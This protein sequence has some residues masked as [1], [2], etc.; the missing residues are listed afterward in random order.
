MSSKILFIFEG[1]KTERQITDSLTRFYVNENINIQCAFCSDIYQLYNKLSSDTDLD[2]FE[3]LK[4]RQQ[5]KDILSGYTRNDFA[6]IYLFF[7]YDGHATNANDDVIIKL[8]SFFNEETEVGKIFI[9]YPMVESI[10]H[11]SNHI[12]FKE[13]KVEAKININYKNRVHNECKTKLRDLSTINENDW[14]EIIELH[15]KKMNHIVNSNFVIPEILI[16][17]NIIFSKQLEKFINVDSSISVLSA[18]PVFIFEY[19]GVKHTIEKILKVT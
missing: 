19:Y 1:E 14:K 17:Q 3:L 9:S 5:N 10:K 8:L 13:L 16:S 12:D 7:D 2:T 11:F 15:L 18:F 4:K 6:E